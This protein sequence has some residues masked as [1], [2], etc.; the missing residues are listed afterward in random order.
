[1]SK[2]LAVDAR[3]GAAGDM[4]LGALVDLGAD[5]NS[6]QA[7]IN[8]VYPNLVRLES[9]KVTRCGVSATKVSVIELE[10]SHHSRLWS[11]IEDAILESTLT[12]RTKELSHKIFDL[13]AQVESDAHQIPLSEVHFHE[14]GAVDS[15]ADIIGTAALLVDLDIDV[16]RSGHLEVGSGSIMSEHGILDIPAPATERLLRGKSYTTLLK[17]ECLTPTGAAIIAALGHV[18]KVVTLAAQRGVGAGS[19]NPSEYPNILQVSILDDV[20]EDIQFQIESNI[21]DIDPRLIPVVIEKLMS[22]GALDAWV[23]PIMMKKNRPGFTLK[24]LCNRSDEKL[25]G[26][27]I[28][29]ETSSI[30]YRTI[31]VEKVALERHFREIEVRAT[32]VSIKIAILDGKIIQVSPEFD[33]INSLAKALDVPTRVAMEEARLAARDNGFVFGALFSE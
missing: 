32:K 11:D 14:V 1:M 6:A 15:I 3:Y 13:L 23:E 21:D 22:A 28:F 16:L 30:G 7:A 27:I 5:L 31:D 9:E 17:G 2:T 20:E 24:V 18:E 19:R 8:Q 25:L 26:R 12:S 4:F 29:E 33:E 10:K